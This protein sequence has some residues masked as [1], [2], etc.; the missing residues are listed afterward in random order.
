MNLPGVLDI[1]LEL[2]PYR[3]AG[4]YWLREVSQSVIAIGGH[5][6]SLEVIGG[7]LRSIQGLILIIKEALWGGW[8]DGRDWM[9]WLS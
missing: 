5:W 8:T 1:S 7:R 6:R 4:S 9:G 3:K 2:A